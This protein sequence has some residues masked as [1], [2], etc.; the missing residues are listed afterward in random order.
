[1]YRDTAN[2]PSL[3]VTGNLHYCL[4]RCRDRSL[5]AAATNAAIAGR[6]RYSRPSLC[7]CMP[8]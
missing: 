8:S 6:C 4:S 1:L 3:S 5:W 7:L 2:Q